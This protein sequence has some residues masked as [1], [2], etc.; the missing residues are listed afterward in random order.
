M[1]M[2]SSLFHGVLYQPIFNVFVWL[3]NVLPAH[4]VGFVI[5]VITIVIRLLLYP[6]TT[7]SIKAQKSM[8]DIQPKMEEVK[9][10]Y[11]DD[12]QKQSTELMKLYKNNK[13]N[14]FSSCLPILIQLPILIAL[15]MVLRDGLNSNNLAENLYPF[16]SNP[17][18]INSFTLGFV[19][20]K[21]ASPVLAILAGAAQYWQARMMLKKKAPAQAGAGAKDENMA[22]MMS[23]Q[24]M[25]MMPALTVII[26]MSLPAGLTLYWFLSTL[27][28][29]VQQ[30]VTFK[31]NNKEDE[32]VIEG[33]IVE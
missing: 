30:F 8:Q 10:K 22:A 12:K 18:I 14:P 13:V 15:Y 25:Y 1:F 7:S 2:F 11:K 4:D 26:G 5:L 32:K 3:Y 29:G 33:E 28:M 31:K 19:D 24:M 20:L 17:G 9:K 16:I 6:L 23:K 27:L 21:V